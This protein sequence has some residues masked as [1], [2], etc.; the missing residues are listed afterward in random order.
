MGQAVTHATFFA[1]EDP[2]VTNPKSFLSKWT[3]PDVIHQYI[4]FMKIYNKLERKLKGRHLAMIAL[5]GTIGTGLL[6]VS[7]ATIHQ[8]GPGSAFVSY[9]IMSFLVYFLMTSLG[10]MSAFSPTTG[11]FCEYATHYVDRAFGF[12]MSWN[13]WLIWVLVIASELIAAGFIMQFWF[14]NISVWV[15]SALFFLLIL[16]V[17]LS[18]VKRYG[19][20]EYWMA[21]IKICT[22]VIFLVLGF[23]AIF[24]VIG[25]QGPVG[26]KNITLGDA[27]FHNGL[28][29]FM[30]V[31]LV[32]GYSFQGTE[33]VG[34]AAGEVEN[35]R[36]TIPVAISKIFTRIILFYVLTILVIGFL[37]PY[38]NH[39][40]A[41]PGHDVAMSPLTL[42]F[43]EIGIPY[44]A[45]IMNLVV[46]TAI[47]S[48]ANASLYTASRVLWYMGRVKEAPHCLERTNRHGVPVLSIFISAGCCLVLFFTSFLG[49][50]AVF[51]WLL[52]MTGLA[53]FIAWFGIALSHYRFRKAYILQ[54]NRLEDL[55]YRAKWFPFSPLFAMF[56]IG[57]IICGQPLI[58]FFHHELSF[59]FL[60]KMYSGVFV[61][62]ILWFSYKVVHNTQ[63]VALEKAHI[64]S[65]V[66]YSR[67][68]SSMEK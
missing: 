33:L 36:Q 54:G 15:W 66:P 68:D 49:T 2:I 38:T 34:I 52:D 53:G 50:G 56:F 9:A 29:G 44:A 18:T 46:L 26:F 42:I 59:F 55:P 5:G 60:F 67:E 47:V 62:L 48:A 8:S 57:L 21:F 37:L 3:L 35:P 14:P 24:G 31:L 12:A 25:H 6:V 41:N 58:P 40:L 32:V 43:Q 45:G 16:G 28:I 30:S 64:F 39:L 27:P 65:E 63:W 10:E 11:S 61:F 17:N 1:P 22:I 23:M 13:Y 7:G 51:Y 4:I 20:S 19:E